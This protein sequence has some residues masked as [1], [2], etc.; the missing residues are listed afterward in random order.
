[1]Q[2][3][4]IVVMVKVLDFEFLPSKFLD[5]SNIDNYSDTKETMNL[6]LDEEDKLSL[7]STGYQWIKTSWY[8]V[9]II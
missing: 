8:I 2:E 6:V 1:M 4:S 7:M 9:C 3:E 5:I